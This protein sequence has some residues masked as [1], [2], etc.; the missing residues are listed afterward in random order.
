VKQTEEDGRTVR[1]SI[2][3]LLHAYGLHP[4]KRLGQNFLVDPVAL[5]RIV[6][7]ADLSSDDLVVEVGAGL[8]TLTRPMAER[9]GHVLALELDD[10]LVEVLREQL[11]DLPNVEIVHGDVLQF[12]GSASLPGRT[13]SNRNYKVVSNLPYNIT[14]AVLRHFLEK[15]PRPRLMVVTVQR[16]VAERIVAG[17]GK[18]SLLAVSVQYYGQPRLVARIP[19]GAFYPPPQ[20]DSAVVRIDVAEHAAVWLEVEADGD[21]VDEAAFF[22]VVRAGFSQK[23]KTLRNSLSAGLGLSPAS[24]EKVLEQAGVNPQR[25][26]ETLSLQEWAHLVRPLGSLPQ[27]DKG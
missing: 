1:Q 20:V 18:M 23:R 16:E 6:A 5:G 7:A 25:R 13:L 27:K 4:R 17:P 19:A 14:S 21:Q 11:A 8:G 15:E 26:A 10:R 12:S 22:R 2:P 24:V 9:A 3:A